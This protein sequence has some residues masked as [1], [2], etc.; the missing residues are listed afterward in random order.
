MGRWL[1]ANQDDLRHEYDAAAGIPVT[2]L[3]RPDGTVQAKTVQAKA[4]GYR[5]REWFERELKR[6]VG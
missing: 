5:D 2:W 1:D 4:V 3:I 6:L